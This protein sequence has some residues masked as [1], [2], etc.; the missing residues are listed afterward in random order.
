[1]HRSTGIARPRFWERAEYYGELDAWRRRSLPPR[2]TAKRAMPM[3]SNE[4][5]LAGLLLLAVLSIAAIVFLLINPYL[6]GEHRTDKRIQGVT[7]NRA[8]RIAIKKQVEAATNRRASSSDWL[9]T[10]S[11]GRPLSRCSNTTSFK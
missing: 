10:S 4:L 9:P 8:K 7:E 11:W 3:D 6:S 5:M 2:R 1:L